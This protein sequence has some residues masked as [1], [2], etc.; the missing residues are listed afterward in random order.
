M[1]HQREGIITPEA[2]VLELR[3][4]GVASRLVAKSIDLAIQVILIYLG[5]LLLAVLMGGVGSIGNL[6]RFVVAVSVWGFVV[7][8]VAPILV[9]RL[10]RG[11]SLGKLMLG[12]KVVTTT[13]GPITVRHALIRGLLQPFEIYTGLAIFPALTTRPTRRFGDLVAGTFVLS[14]RTVDS[15]TVPTAFLPPWGYEPYVDALDVGRV[16]DAQYVFIRALLLRVGQLSPE[17]RWHLTVRA[18]E[19]ATALVTPLPH[20]GIAPEVFLVCV[21]GAYQRRT[22]AIPP[23][24]FLVPTRGPTQGPTRGSGPGPGPAPVRLGPA[25]PIWTEAV[26]PRPAP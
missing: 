11:R 3:A 13:G 25:P 2:V 23:E 5:A 14:D 17:G 9:E 21:A 15:S 24:A 16:T 8:I 22:G 19:A 6:D 10:S 7:L 26:P 12:L 4:A 18:A 20:A 1:E